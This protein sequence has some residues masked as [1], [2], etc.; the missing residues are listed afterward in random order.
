MICCN[1]SN[2]ED[3]CFVNLTSSGVI[4]TNNQKLELW[5]NDSNRC[6]YK[7]GYT[8]SFESKFYFHQHGDIETV[9]SELIYKCM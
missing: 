5:L 6:N 7:S 4:S 8:I 2:Q 9:I 1:S 3:C